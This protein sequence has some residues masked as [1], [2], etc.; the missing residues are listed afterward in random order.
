MTRDGRSARQR[1]AP[2]GARPDRL[3]LSRRRAAAQICAGGWNITGDTYLMDEDGYF[4]YQARSD[5]M[6]ISAGLQYRR[7]GGRGGAADPSGRRRMR[8]GRR[9]RRR[10]AAWSSRPM[11]SCA[12]AMRP[13]RDLTKASRITSRRRSRPTNI[14]ARSSSWR[15][16]RDADRQL[17]RF[18]L[19]RM[20]GTRRAI[21]KPC[22]HD[23]QPV[24]VGRLTDAG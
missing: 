3:P 23:G 11:S 13:V 2:R 20:A 15:R 12:P 18:E 22:E 14:L 16:C 1:R 8:R 9:A 6:I 7:A 24:R 21:R 5:D 17:Q 10:I 19:R 4:W